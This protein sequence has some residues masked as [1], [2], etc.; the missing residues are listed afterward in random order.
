M[1]KWQEYEREKAL[2]E[3]QELSGAEY[4]AALRTIAKKLG[5]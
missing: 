5:L 3:K 2:L 1:D 4:A